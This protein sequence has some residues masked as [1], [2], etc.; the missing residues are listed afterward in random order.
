[1]CHSI[2]GFLRYLWIASGSRGKPH[3]FRNTL[4]APASRCS[5]ATFSPC[6]RW[7]FFLYGLNHIFRQIVV[8]SFDLHQHPLALRHDL[9]SWIKPFFSKHFARPVMLAPDTDMIRPTSVIYVWPLRRNPAPRRYRIGGRPRLIGGKRERHETASE[10]SY[11]P[12]D[13]ADLFGFAQ[14]AVEDRM[15]SPEQI[16]SARFIKV[17]AISIL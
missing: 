9:K 13:G 8:G 15:T 6:H 11:G 4:L 17:L 1:M 3:H 14:F 2:T 7:I 10:R 16:K 5:E 12:D